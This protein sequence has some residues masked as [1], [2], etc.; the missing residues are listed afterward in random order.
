MIH[1][2]DCMGGYYE[3]SNSFWARLLTLAAD[4]G[5]EPEGTVLGAFVADDG[6]T[7]IDTYGTRADSEEGRKQITVWGGGYDSNDCQ[8]VSD[9][10]A[11]GMVVALD[12]ALGLMAADDPAKPHVAE[13]AEFARTSVGFIIM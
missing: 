4:H 5:W 2:S 3:A 11:H 8:L 1:L 10:D 7:V 12:K 6:N 9:A 13:F